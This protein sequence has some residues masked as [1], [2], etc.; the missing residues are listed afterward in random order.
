MRPAGY[1]V[2]P[3]VRVSP[4]NHSINNSAKAVARASPG[5]SRRDEKAEAALQKAAELHSILENLQKVNDEGRRSSLLDL[6]CPID[7]RDFIISCSV[8]LTV[9]PPRIY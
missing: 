5:A 8:F 4:S 9:Y 3:N 1:Q 2:P 7:V 6:V